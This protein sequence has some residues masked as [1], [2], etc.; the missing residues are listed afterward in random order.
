M[1]SNP[2]NNT[3]QTA[4]VL[5]IVGS[6]AT[7]SSGTLSAATG[8]DLLDYYK[9]T[10]T[11]AS[12]LNLTL[13]G[14]TGNARLAVFR[15]EANGAQGTELVSNISNNPSA[16]KNSGTLAESFIVNGLDA[17]TYLIRVDL[18]DN[19]ATTATAD[20]ILSGLASVDGVSTSIAWRSPGNTPLAF[21][22]VNGAAYQE[23]GLFFGGFEIVG[24]GDFDGDKTTDLI[25]RQ[26]GVADSEMQIW[27]MN[28]DN[29]RKGEPQ[30]VNLPGNPNTLLPG[31]IQ[32]D[33]VQDLNGDNKADI[34]WRDTAGNVYFWVMDGAT[35]VGSAT[36]FG[37]QGYD[38]VGYG[39]FNGD[40]KKDVLWQNKAAGLTAIWLMNGGQTLA[41]NFVTTPQAMTTRYKVLGVDNLNVSVGGSTT[42]PT[43][44][45]KTDVLWYDN[46][47]GE[48]LLW[49]MDGGTI[50]RQTKSS[51]VLPSSGWIF[52]ASGDVSGD[53]NMDI[54]WRNVFSGAVGLWLLEGNGIKDAEFSTN[55]I[56][57]GFYIEGL[58]DLNGD[59]A[60]DILW[61]WD[62]QPTSPFA[63]FDD[64]V[65]VWLMGGGTR[66]VQTRAEAFYLNVGAPAYASENFRK[67]PQ[68]FKARFLTTQFTKIDQATAGS[69]IATAFNMGVLNGEGDY[70]DS[71]TPDAPNAPVSDFYKFKLDRSTKTT[72]DMKTAFGSPSNNNPNATF[73]VTREVVG[74][75]GAITLVPVQLNPGE[76]FL[77]GTKV[78]L[79]GVYY[80][81]VKTAPAVTNP[82]TRIS[83]NLKVKGEPIVVNL[84]GEG[85]AVGDNATP[86]QE[87]SKIT[88]V[89]LSNQPPSTPPDQ[90]TDKTSIKVQ[91][92]IKNSEISNSGPVK[93]NFY[94]SR[95]AEITPG[96]TGPGTDQLLN[97]TPI[98][99]D[100][101]SGAGVPASTQITG[102]A[103]LQLP[104]GDNTFWT[105]D[106]NYY[107]GMVIDPL[108][109]IFETNEEDN[110][111]L[112]LLKDVDLIR[113]EN[114]QVPDLLSTAISTTSS[115][116]ITKGGTVSVAYSIKNQGKRATGPINPTVGIEF[117]LYRESTD[118]ELTPEQRAEFP[119][120]IAG[121]PN[122]TPLD[123]SVPVADPAV[124]I[125]AGA[126]VTAPAIQ[127]TLPDANDVFW[128]DATPGTVFYIGTR[129]DRGQTFAESDELNN[130]DLGLGIDRLRFT[131]A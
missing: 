120:S 67:M 126:T 87:A 10:T 85:L 9:F 52:Q 84:F 88:L 114:T 16:T 35:V 22:K 46:L 113:I 12:N 103:T 128:T 30:R 1:P 108:N 102:E 116:T 63:A 95:D 105:T 28:P 118:P 71:V 101:T 73:R 17:G 59:N 111:K 31:N 15:V 50:A 2:N 32:L 107:I 119:L 14:L 33:N 121:L 106:G 72:I 38:I 78:L 130:F 23:S 37:L 124:G 64:T 86:F 82:A 45:K 91:Y 93:L 34:I 26:T 47:T 115:A 125:E 129:I 122:L 21:W 109:E 62:V 97:S 41:T 51:P 42:A 96:Q 25:W 53:G 77:S 74:E 48:V 98:I 29:T 60:K 11:A 66:G 8:G 57:D 131:L 83:Y 110:S 55:P 49:T 4:S 68:D 92:K 6:T 7:T 40:S 13:G 54:V 112:G 27:L 44:D 20:Y 39:D 80:V 127:L 75:N 104:P 99:Y 100:G 43:A 69:T 123:Y 36:Y 18:G 81:E 19:P 117:F 61:R 70:Q 3:V 5:S 94:L 79:P 56:L 76:S 89:P 65:A 90:R 58:A 24:T